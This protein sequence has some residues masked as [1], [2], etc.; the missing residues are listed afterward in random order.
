MTSTQKLFAFLVG[1]GILLTA[2]K[3]VGCVREDTPTYFDRHPNIRIAKEIE[4]A[5]A[6]LIDVETLAREIS[7][8]EIAAEKKYKGMVLRVRGKIIS[9][10]AGK[11]GPTGTKPHIQLGPAEGG[12][13]LIDC[14]FRENSE[15]EPL[16][17]GQTVTIKG[18][19]VGD[20]ILLY[21]MVKE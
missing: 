10:K 9:I 13:S 17:T 12:K 19:Y 6:P 1:A 4:D 16:A 18:K 14:E 8:N 15:L 7:A 3:F 2:L 11:S 20:R 5:P 21:C